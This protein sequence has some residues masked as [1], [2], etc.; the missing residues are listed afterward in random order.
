MSANIALAFALSCLGG[1]IT[2]GW[3]AWRAEQQ[4]QTEQNRIYN[5]P[6]NR[7]RRMEM[8]IVTMQ[9]RIAHL[10]EQIDEILDLPKG[11]RS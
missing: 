10:Q 2:L 9:K 3:R 7:R 11:A 1:I 6:A 8:E 5:L 4:R